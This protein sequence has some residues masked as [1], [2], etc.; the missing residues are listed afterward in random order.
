MM[1]VQVP[2]GPPTEKKG[3]D[4]AKMTEH[5]HCWCFPVSW[6]IRNTGGAEIDG[7]VNSKPTTR[8]EEVRYMLCCHCGCAS[9]SRTTNGKERR[10]PCQNDGACALLVFPGQLVDQEHRRGRDRRAC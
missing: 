5:A 6:S 7:R 8:D 2:H 3:G 4:H 1:G 10:R 9:P